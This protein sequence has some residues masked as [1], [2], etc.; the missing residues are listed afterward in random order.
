M[1]TDQWEL[2]DREVPDDPEDILRLDQ[3]LAVHT[4]VGHRTRYEILY[5][6][7]LQV[8]LVTNGSLKPQIGD[9]V[10]EEIVYG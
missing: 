9:R 5:Q 2:I 4:A 10:D 3:Y 6:L 7:G 1:A 8:D